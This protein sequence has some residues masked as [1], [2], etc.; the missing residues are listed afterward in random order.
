MPEKTWENT[1][2]YEK[3]SLPPGKLHKWQKARKYKALRRFEVIKC[4]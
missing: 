4:T 1:G 2:I 3:K